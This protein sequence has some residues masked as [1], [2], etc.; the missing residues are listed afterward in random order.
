MTKRERRML[1]SLAGQTEFE[2]L[3]L[4]A[5]TELDQPLGLGT[6]CLPYRTSLLMIDGEGKAP[7]WCY[8]AGSRF[9]FTSDTA[10]P[11]A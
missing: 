1:R 11:P 3:G 8:S 7:E 2:A 10:Q 4:L 5:G 6:F 9:T